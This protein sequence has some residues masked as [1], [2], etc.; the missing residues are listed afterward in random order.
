MF[1]LV[2]DICALHV[3]SSTGFGD[4]RRNPSI[5]RTAIRS[6][7]RRKGSAQYPLQ[8]VSGG[9]RQSLGV[10]ARS[11]E[12]G[13]AYLPIFPYRISERYCIERLLDRIEWNEAPLHRSLEPLATFA[14]PR[15]THFSHVARRCVQRLLILYGVSRRWGQLRDNSKRQI[16][17]SSLSARTRILAKVIWLYV[18]FHYAQFNSKN[19]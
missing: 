2:G 5:F 15:M 3:C 7:Y 1:L 13:E 17:E 4:H 8:R 18:D 19:T 6:H 16:A 14:R 9:E 10:F 11:N 12:K